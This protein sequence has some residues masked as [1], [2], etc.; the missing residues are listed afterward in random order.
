V[1]LVSLF[2]GWAIYPNE[3]QTREFLHRHMWR[4]YEEIKN[5]LKD[6]D[7]KLAK[8]T[9]LSERHILLSVLSTT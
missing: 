7:C 2:D 6:I 9:N 8:P 5:K 1:A 4:Q 3:I